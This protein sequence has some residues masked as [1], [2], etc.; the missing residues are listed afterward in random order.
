MNKYYITFGQKYRN[1]KHPGGGHPDGWVTVYANSMG[2]ARALIS[3]VLGIQ[4][5]FIYDE[6]D[7]KADHFSKGELY[8]IH[9]EGGEDEKRTILVG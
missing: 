9:M 4:W 5:A 2:E 6:T 8:A 3:N 7:F 1:E